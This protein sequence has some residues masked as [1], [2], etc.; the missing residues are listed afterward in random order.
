MKNRFTLDTEHNSAFAGR[1]KKATMARINNPCAPPRIND[2][3]WSCML[4]D[5][6]PEDDEQEF[7]EMLGAPV[8]QQQ[9]SCFLACAP[10]EPAGRRKGDRID[11]RDVLSRGGLSH[12][13]HSLRRNG[14]P[15]IYSGAANPEAPFVWLTVP[16]DTTFDDEKGLQWKETQTREQHAARTGRIRKTDKIE[17][18][19]SPSSST[20]GRSV[21]PKRSDSPLPLPT[22]R[23]KSR[24]AKQSRLRPG[25]SQ[26]RSSASAGSRPSAVTSK[27][28]TSGSRSS[29]DRA[30][31]SWQGSNT[32][33][34]RTESR[35]ES[36]RAS[37]SAKSR[38]GRSLSLSQNS[39]ST[40]QSA[41]KLVQGNRTVKSRSKSRQP[42][43]KNR[44]G[45][46]NDYIRHSPA[47]GAVAN[48]HILTRQE[49][50]DDSSYYR[51]FGSRPRN[52]GVRSGDE[53]RQRDRH[54][55]QDEREIPH[56]KFETSRT[57]EHNSRSSSSK[58]ERVREKVAL[59]HS[60]R[61]SSSKNE[62]LQLQE[63]VTLERSSRS[64]SSKNGWSLEKLVKKP[65]I[66]RRSGPIIRNF[67][68]EYPS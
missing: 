2:A 13:S 56:R 62:K 51:R 20:R 45:D 1:A 58:M 10:D 16:S 22:K 66:D 67:E 65:S 27:S 48:A 35:T 24:G 25:E 41:Q 39:R 50:R 42:D 36:S 4:D 18:K 47:P 46:G 26:S 49:S 9:A 63:N 54:M 55:L 32:G 64:F 40:N 21:P 30:D 68:E 60:S 44:K 29:V 59:E 14:T 33:G 19:R 12:M 17:V 7:H 52:I 34:S 57:L 6:V 11:P 53:S 61:S 3:L 43:N 15:G 38:T 8:A 31:A 37:S 23:T 28:G 5:Y